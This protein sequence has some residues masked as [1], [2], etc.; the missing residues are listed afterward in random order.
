MITNMR[1]DG[2]FGEGTTVTTNPVSRVT[3]ERAWLVTAG[4]DGEVSQIAVGFAAMMDAVVRCVWADPSEEEG[5][6]QMHEEMTDPDFWSGDFWSCE[7]AFEDGYLR[8]Q[9]ITDVSALRA[10]S[11]N[12]EGEPKRWMIEEHTPS[13]AISWQVVEHKLHAQMVAE[14]LKNPS[15][16]SPLY[17]RPQP[18]QVEVSDAARDVLA[19][20][21]R[22]ISVEG[23]T[24]D[25]D[26]QHSR[27]EMAQAAMSYAMCVA[28]GP[29]NAAIWWPWGVEWFKPSAPRRNLVKA[30]ALILAEIERLDR[31][32]ALTAALR[33]EQK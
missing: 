7:W 33:S 11:P 20:R 3:D 9:R 15:T 27:F 10:L 22:Q 31:A 1:E 16:V 21:Q 19:E 24:S 12:S 30:A 4:P 26:D 2:E 14:D 17:A 5:A 32:A 18:Q 13:G 28:I 29:T 8:V 23:W 6:E 25:H